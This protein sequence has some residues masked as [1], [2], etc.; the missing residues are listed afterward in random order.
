M[1]AV[2]GVL[3]VLAFGAAHAALIVPIWSRLAGGVPFAIMAASALAWAIDEATPDRSAT[4]ASGLRDGAL[5]W[6]TLLPLTIADNAMRL[7]DRRLDGPLELA[8]GL[9]ATLACGAWIGW[10]RTRHA[11]GVWAWA[12]ATLSFTIV[13]GGPLPFVRS[14]RGASIALATLPICAGAGALIAAASAAVR[15]PPFRVF[16]HNT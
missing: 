11:G 2:I 3:A 13:A 6:V 1:G 12:A 14:V 10:R 9:T 5:V 4:V 8:A 15:R 16:G 7:F